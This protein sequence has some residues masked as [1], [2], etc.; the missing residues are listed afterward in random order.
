MPSGVPRSCVRVLDCQGP[1]GRV[2]EKPSV[3]VAR[4][5]ASPRP[6]RAPTM[7][8]M[9]WAITS[10]NVARSV[11]CGVVWCGVVWCGVVWCGVVWCGVVWCGVVWCG[12]VWCGVVWCGV[13][14]AVINLPDNCGL[15]Y[16]LK[17]DMFGKW[18]GACLS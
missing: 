16:K 1:K 12:V 11:W 15:P 14:R 3:W 2:Y 18:N 4:W 6:T 17:F 7:G 13:V 8:W 5:P 10:K 9:S